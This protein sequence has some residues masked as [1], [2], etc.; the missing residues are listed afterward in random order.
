MKIDKRNTHHWIALLN[1]ALI[2]LIAA[3]LRFFI[4][5]KKIVL[6][7][8]HKLN[9]NLLPIFNEHKRH[10][11]HSWF[12]SIDADYLLSIQ[13]DHKTIC[14]LCS[15]KSAIILA[16]TK[17]IITSHGL[18][19]LIIFKYLSNVKLVDVWHGIPFKGFDGEDFKVQHT[20][21]E[22]WVT[23]KKLK[24]IYTNIFSFPENIVHITGYA[25]TD[26]I[27][28]PP[29]KENLKR[30]Y[31]IPKEYNNIVMFCPTWAQNDSNRNIFPF[32]SS[33]N[34][35][36]LGICNLCADL[37]TVFILRSHLNTKHINLTSPTP[38][39]LILLPAD[40][41][42]HTEEILTMCDMLIC[43]WSSVAFDFLLLNRPTIFLDVSPPFKKPMALDATYRFGEIVSNI[44]D[45]FSKIQTYITSPESYTHQHHEKIMRIREELYESN[46]DGFAAARCAKRLQLLVSAT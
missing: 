23:S 41:Y 22:V 25:R 35:F 3:S 27:I 30:K 14:N 38:P 21:N 2:A 10:N 7:Y 12:G 5:N 11:G 39:N 29:P 9:G 16:K 40:I 33:A 8:G 31:S 19:S 32:S 15:I 42:P 17:V 6:F 18:H 1:M 28:S 20:Y 45:L 36:L 46:A 44:E 37:S 24:N 13:D 26:I 34:S 43:D 4:R